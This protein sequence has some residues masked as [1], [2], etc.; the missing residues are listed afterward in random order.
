MPPHG[1]VNLGKSLRKGEGTAEERFWD[2]VEKTQTC[3]LW[4]AGTKN[5]GYGVF[6]PERDRTY[7]AHR[8]GWTLT[9]GPIPGG[10]LV[11]HTCDNKLCVRPEHLFLGTPKD[12]MDDMR[13]KGRARWGTY[14]KVKTHCRN[15]H[16]YTPENTETDRRGRRACRICRRANNRA[17]YRRHAATIQAASVEVQSSA[18]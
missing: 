11:C 9:R 14:N 10:M 1:R 12:N 18:A 3:W 17:A 5:S 16:E 7:M 8:Y 4:I 15:G 2:R 13:E 6:A